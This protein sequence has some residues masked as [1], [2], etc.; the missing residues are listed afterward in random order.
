M[1][2][3]YSSHAAARVNGCFTWGFERKKAQVDTAPPI[4]G[5]L[6]TDVEMA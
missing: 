1:S 3:Y 6:F 4:K 2:S 5:L